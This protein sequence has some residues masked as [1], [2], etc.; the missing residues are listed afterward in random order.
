MFIARPARWREAGRRYVKLTPH[1]PGDKS[2]VE[3]ALVKERK[4]RLN[5]CPIVTD[6]IW[7]GFLTSSIS[8]KTDK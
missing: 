2:R 3:A 5:I 1:I 7:A 6:G 4:V 8:I